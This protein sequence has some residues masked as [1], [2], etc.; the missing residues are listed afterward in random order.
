MFQNN[1][2]K[3]LGKYLTFTKILGWI[4][5]IADQLQIWPTTLYGIIVFS[6]SDTALLPYTV[7][8]YTETDCTGRFVKM[9]QFNKLL[10]CAIFRA[11]CLP[12]PW[13]DKLHGTLTCLT[14]P[15]TTKFGCDPSRRNRCELIEFNFP[16]RFTQSYNEFFK[17]SVSVTSVLQLV[18]RR[19]AAPD[20]KNI[21]LTT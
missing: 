1:L 14:Y 15:A 16:Q 6:V 21:P 18:S 9:I 2:S 10:H 13:Q 19:F 4:I 7:W 8:P 5:L 11:T 3:W 12:T 17:H 20:K